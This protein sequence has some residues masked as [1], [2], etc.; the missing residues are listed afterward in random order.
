[1]ATVGDAMSLVW[2]T[3]LPAQQHAKRSDINSAG[4]TSIGV[5]HDPSSFS[6]RAS[7]QLRASEP[8]TMAPVDASYCLPPLRW[9]RSAIQ[10][11]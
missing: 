9:S 1:M 7:N 11:A 2:S 8:C 4:I 10:R 6:I 5:T 3:A